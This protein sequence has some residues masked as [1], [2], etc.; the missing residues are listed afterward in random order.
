M[1]KIVK[2]LIVILGFALSAFQV[3]TAATMPFTA[4]IQRSV[5]LGLGMALVFLVYPVA[6][7]KEG[8]GS[9]AGQVLDLMLM[10]LALISCLYVSVNWEALSEPERLSNPTIWDMCFGVIAFLL[11]LEGTRRVAG[12]AL[13]IIALVA[14]LYIFTGPWM[15]GEL[16]HPG[17]SLQN[18]ISLGYMFNEGIFG[19]PIEAS[20]S[21]VFIFILFGQFLQSLRGSDFFLTLANS[22]VGTL[23]GGPAKVAIFASGF[24]G[25]ISGSAVANVVG[26]GSVT[27]PLMKRVGYKPEFA[28]AVE[29]VASTG[30]LIM[31]PV[32]GAA[33]FI[34]A[35]IVGISY[36]SIVVAAIIPALLYYV[37]LYIAVDL[38]ARRRQLSGLPR[39]DVPRF[40]EVLRQ[41]GWV[42]ITP[43]AV[44][45][46]LL[47]IY[48]YSPARACFWSIVILISLCSVKRELR[49]LLKGALDI[50]TQAAKNAL[51][52][53]MACACAGLV[54]LMFQVT[55]LGLKFSSILIALAGENL[56]LLMFLVMTASL[57]LGMGLPATA[58]YIILALLAAPA[59]VELGGEVMAAHLFVMYFGALSAITPPVC[60]AA[61][62]A[63][64]IS[65]AS[66]MRTGFVAW[67][68]ALPIFLVA[69]CFVLQPELLMIG[70]PLDIVIVS[71]SCL[72][73]VAAMAVGLEGYWL[74]EIGI[75]RRL[76][77][78]IAGALLIW[79]NHYLTVGGVLLVLI[80]V[81]CDPQVTQKLRKMLNIPLV[82]ESRTEAIKKSL[83]D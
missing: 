42:Y 1:D 65:G 52:V 54:L 50:F 5:H 55:G 17:A 12:P 28:G 63:S 48:Q 79:P 25:S 80:C 74:A 33:A 10:L 64:G 49:P 53:I 62:A 27:I 11:V 68:I 78:I 70:K 14:L 32:M 61:Y 21:M 58:C 4:M 13:P 67:R 81:M 16:K 44:L 46:L 23:R 83:E 73:G 57:I 31:P 2:F 56:L 76:L 51:V 75:A 45:V 72:A 40:G 24:F 22:L 20:A 8:I 59:I 43:L 47:G 66:P 7:R 19:S 30:G 60:L 6:K 69:Y 77:W 82:G 9:L 15:P 37:G 36:W 38:R 26:T 34:M 35:E 41:N 29:S 3:Y 39:E 71:V 18:V